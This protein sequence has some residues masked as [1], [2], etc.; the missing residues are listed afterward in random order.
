VGD[1]PPPPRQSPTTTEAP[2]FPQGR[3]FFVSLAEHKDR[4]AKDAKSA[5]E[6]QEFG[7]ADDR[8]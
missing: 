8:R 1:Y 2:A 3:G 5:K 4:T 7:T 6:M